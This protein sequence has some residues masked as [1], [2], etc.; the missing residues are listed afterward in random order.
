M[1]GTHS[2]TAGAGG[3]L[4]AVS[5]GWAAPH[6]CAAGRACLLLGCRNVTESQNHGTVWVGRDL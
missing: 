5:R 3:G 1:D 2:R 6:G 4:G